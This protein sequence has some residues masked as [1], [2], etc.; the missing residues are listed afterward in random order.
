MISVMAA[1]EN[2]Y[3]A[4][5]E[6]SV[7]KAILSKNNLITTLLKSTNWLDNFFSTTDIALK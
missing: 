4:E 6:T 3:E 5:S 7:H 1:L 2:Q